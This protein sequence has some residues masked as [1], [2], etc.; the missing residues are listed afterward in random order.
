MP[1]NSLKQ[2]LARM[3]VAVFISY[4][5]VAVALPVVPI[6]VAQELGLA[7][8]LGGFA[9]GAA[10]IST[11]LSRN[12][13]GFYADVRSPKKCTLLGLLYY[14]SA[15]GVCLASAYCCIPKSTAF[16]VLIIGRLI[17]GLGESMTLVG[18][19]SWNL[20]QL[21]PQYSGRI[22][23]I[24]GIAMYGAFA[25]GGPIGIMIYEQHGFAAV[26][27]ISTLLPLIGG[28]LLISAA[29]VSPQMNIAPRV[30][31]LK[32]THLIWKQGTVVCLQGVGFAVLGAFISL[33]FKSKGWPYAGYGISL[34]G[35]GFVVS[36][37]LFSGLPDKIG[38]IGLAFFSL[39]VEMLGQGLLWGAQDVSIALI[40]ALLTGLGCSMIFPAMGVEVIKQVPQGLRGTAFG[41]FAAFQDVA[42]AFSA[43]I[44][45]WLADTFNYSSVFL[46]GAMA[47]ASGLAIVIS[48]RYTP[49]PKRNLTV[50]EEKSN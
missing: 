42:Y 50:I 44:A 45:G 36:R 4:L 14:I 49:K 8:W 2:C 47:A 7:N 48:M 37:I 15:A 11:I 21:G 33:Y 13:A 27:G 38:G 35:I 17:L 6:F 40:G 10:F 25:V 26:M 29:D 12:Y 22:L 16:F 1:N 46:L 28:G 32:I 19:T 34:F 43:P 31:F 24:V 3:G 30:P 18:L 5:S 41:G 20:A 23:S 39:I 9:V